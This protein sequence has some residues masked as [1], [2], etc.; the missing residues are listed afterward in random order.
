MNTRMAWTFC[1]LLILGVCPRASAQLATGETAARLDS[2]ALAIRAAEELPGLTILVAEGSDVVFGRGYGFADLDHEVPAGIETVYGLGSIT[3][4]FIA[5]AVLRLADEGRLRLDDEVAA[6]L[7][8]FPA[9]G[10]RLTLHH[11]LGHTSGLP[12]VPSRADRNWFRI[13]YTRE[14]ILSRLVEQYTA[15]EL[16]F[17]PGEAWEYMGTNHSLLGFVIE[18][19]SGRPLWQ[20]IREELLL[21]LGMTVTDVCDPAIVVRNRATG[22]VKNPSMPG[23]LEIP[24]VSASAFIGSAGL[25]SSALDLVRWHQKLPRHLG[26]EA[27]ARMITPQPLGNGVVPDYGYGITR[28]EVEGEPM[29]FHTGAQPGFTAF[30]A[31]LPERDVT[32]AVLTNSNSDILAIGPTVVR[33]AL[34]VPQ[35][36]SLATSPAELTR[37]AGVYGSEALRAEIQAGEDGLTATVRGG[38][39]VRFIFPARLLKQAERV[40]AVGWEPGATFTFDAGDPASGLTL[41]YGGRTVELRRVVEE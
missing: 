5:A 11:L 2:L 19:A 33:A 25:C 21:P 34:G 9:H 30:L 6:H 15:A 24:Y 40:F 1:G 4:E 32:V 31:Y 27:Y 28:W 36:R 41:S 20:Y 39:S 16:R 13:D 18:K 29:L 10:G 7:P 12:N 3:K 37:Y 17:R 23:G 26:E 22:Y 14:E 35:P 8:G 38:H